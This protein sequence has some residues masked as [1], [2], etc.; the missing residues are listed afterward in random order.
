MNRLGTLSFPRVA[1]SGK[2]EAKMSQIQ[3]NKHQ[4]L[5]PKEMPSGPPTPPHSPRTQRIKASFLP[6][7]LQRL[8]TV[9]PP[10]LPHMPRQAAGRSRVQGGLSASGQGCTGTPRWGET[11]P[12]LGMPV[13]NSLSDLEHVSSFFWLS[14]PHLDHEETEETISKLLSLTL[15]R[16]VTGQVSKTNR[17]TLV[18]TKDWGQRA[19]GWRCLV[20][21][22]WRLHL[23][24]GI[25]RITWSLT[26]G[27]KGRLW[28]PSPQSRGQTKEGRAAL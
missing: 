12:G 23:C 4:W 7:F 14:L 5:K 18:V 6:C 15:S 24:P 17:K 9:A 20:T 26:R 21:G 27:R 8:P 28:S 3:P 25:R 19:R 22:A 11:P 13:T 10:P 2:Q 1:S 16:P